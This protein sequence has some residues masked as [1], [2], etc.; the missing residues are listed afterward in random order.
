MG[1]DKIIEIRNWFRKNGMMDFEL[2]KTLPK[3]KH[4]KTITYNCKDIDNVFE[5]ALAEHSSVLQ[6]N[7]LL[8]HVS[9]NE[10]AVCPKCGCDEIFRFHGSNTC[11]NKDCD[12]ANWLLTATAMKS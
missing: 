12:W 6:A 9:N 10:V 11:L 8:P 2:D 5:R 1:K 3:S 4:G 7:E